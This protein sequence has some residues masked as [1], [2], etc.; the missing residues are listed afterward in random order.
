[1]SDMEKQKYLDELQQLKEKQEKRMQYYYD[2]IR[3]GEELT[4]IEISNAKKLFRMGYADT[5]EEGKA[6]VRRNRDLDNNWND[7]FYNRFL[8]TID[9]EIESK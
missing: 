7:W 3:N 4:P 1:M 2:L 5:L 6:T 8:R 9:E